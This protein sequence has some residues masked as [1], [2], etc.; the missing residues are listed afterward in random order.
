MTGEHH[1]E[2]LKRQEEDR[3]LDQA[4][5]ILEKRTRPGQ[6][7]D[8]RAQLEDYLR[9]DLGPLDDEV[10]E[11]I[12]VDPHFQ[13]LA[14]D[15]IGIGEQDS[16]N[17]SMRIACQTALARNADGV[18]FIHNPLWQQ[19]EAIRSGSDI[20]RNPDRRADDLQYLFSRSL[21]HQQPGDVFILPGKG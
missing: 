3:I 16:G 21:D 13:V 20:D 8:S 2:T 6:V 4:L 14:R 19:P 10:T 5:A 1:A 17:V 18:F 11:L 9:L 7:V 12:S 15:R